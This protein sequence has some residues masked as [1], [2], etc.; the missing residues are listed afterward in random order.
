LTPRFLLDTNIIIYIRRK[1]P[2]DVLARCAEMS[3]GEAVMSVVTHGELAYGVEKSMDPKALDVL[4][5][6]VELIPVLALPPRAGTIYGAMRADLARR[7]QMIGGNDLWI[8]THAL[9]ENLTL[10]TN[11]EPEFR[12]VPRL[13]VANWV[14]A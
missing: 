10:V 13:V 8:A 1:R 7:G 9:C 11:N 5:E 14:T 6:L 4:Q 2:K 12:R 3:V